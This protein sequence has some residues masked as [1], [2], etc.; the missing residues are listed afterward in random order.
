[1]KNRISIIILIL[2][3]TIIVR[4]TTLVMGKILYR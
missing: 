1:V 2:K 3:V 4:P